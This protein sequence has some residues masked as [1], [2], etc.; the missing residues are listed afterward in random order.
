MPVKVSVKNMEKVMRTE[1][2]ISQLEEV[3]TALF[4]SNKVVHYDEHLVTEIEQPTKS[5]ETEDRTPHA[6]STDLQDVQ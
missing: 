6:L 5:K 2:D 4:R 3:E 1:L